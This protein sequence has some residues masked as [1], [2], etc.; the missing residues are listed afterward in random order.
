MKET[1]EAARLILTDGMQAAT[2]QIEAAQQLQPELLL[3]KID[4]RLARLEDTF[5]QLSAAILTIEKG[6]KEVLGKTLYAAAQ[7][8]RELGSTAEPKTREEEALQEKAGEAEAGEKTASQ[9]GS[10][11]I[12]EGTSGRTGAVEEAGKQPGIFFFTEFGSCCARIPW[13]KY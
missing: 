2:A 5:M 13:R 7:K 12:S 10:G 11:A 1:W 9:E 4:D 6:K 3:L 8:Q